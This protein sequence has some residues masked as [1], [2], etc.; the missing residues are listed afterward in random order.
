MTATTRVVI[1]EDHT[2]VREGL[3][4]LLGGQEGI[5]VAGACGN[6]REGVRLAAAL[7][8]DVVV[9]DILLP[10]LNGIDA[11]AQIV[12]GT[13]GVKVILLSMYADKEYVRSAIGAGARG[14]ILKGEGISELVKAIESVA[15]GGAFF[16]PP[17]AKLMAD[18]IRV[19]RGEGDELTSRERE[20]LQLIAEGRT[21]A[22][23][24]GLLDISVKTV[25]G[26]RTNL[27]AK[28]DVHN[29]A[30]LIRY[31]IKKGL[32]SA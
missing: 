16:S 13:P 5:E 25:E 1:V 21:S 22:E 31:A 26:H 23:I 15:C 8:P 32:V 2:I 19:L 24:A 20:V 17:V 4:A 9:M 6:G 14:Y 29:V 11:T 18:E 7:K 12:K 3:M 10:E 30:G 28:L 27:M